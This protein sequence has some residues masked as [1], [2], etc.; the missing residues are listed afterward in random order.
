MLEK[1]SKMKRSDDASGL[2]YL[3]VSAGYTTIVSM[4]STGPFAQPHW[5]NHV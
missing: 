2:L 1:Y 3:L 5:T 4:Y